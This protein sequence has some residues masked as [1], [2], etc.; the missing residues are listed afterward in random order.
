[1]KNIYTYLALLMIFL[2]SSCSTS[3][4]YAQSYEPESSAITY[5]QFYNDLSPYGNWVDYQNYGYVWVPDEPGF[6]PYYNNGRWTYTNY[7]WTWVSNYNWGWA[8]FHYGRWF[9]DDAYGWMWVPGYEWAPAWVSWRD[10]GGCY[11]WAPLGPGFNLNMGSRIPYNYW[12]FVPQRYI[13]SP[14]INNYYINQEK[15]VN[16]INNT[17]V[18]NNTKVTQ[19]KTVYVIGPSATEVEKVTNEKIRPAKIVQKNT[20]GNTDVSGGTVSLY[21]PVV[22][23][24][25]Q[26]NEQAK[27]P[28]VVKLNDL[29]V[30]QENPVPARKEVQPNPVVVDTKTQ[31]VINPQKNNNASLPVRGNPVVRTP[32]SVTKEVN[33][34]QPQKVVPVPEQ[35]VPDSRS[36]NI[37]REGNNDQQIQSSNQPD[38]RRPAQTETINQP[39]KIRINEPNRNVENMRQNVSPAPVNRQPAKIQEMNADRPQRMPPQNYKQERRSSEFRQENRSSEFRQENRFPVNH[40]PI[41]RNQSTAEPREMHREMP[42][43]ERK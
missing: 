4:D 3:R 2:I 15:N 7:G 8:P 6:R 36:E 12:T 35:K 30:R 40:Q 23:A 42:Q 27:P 20:P 39:A 26:Q 1:M 5:E 25:A 29:K 37:N 19:N 43:K 41:I 32:N 11:G 14:R 21:K 31:S 16:I 33:A 22:K 10:G 13:N 9:Y 28:K 17:R 34:Q 24:L 38:I 18:I